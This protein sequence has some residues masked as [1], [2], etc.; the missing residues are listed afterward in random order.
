[1]NEHAILTRAAAITFYAIAALVPFMILLIAL[2]ARVFPWL[3]G[4]AASSHLGQP[5][6]ELLPEDANRFIEGQIARLR[7]QP[8]T[9]L[10]SVGLA[11]MLWLTSSVFV[12]IIDAMNCILDVRESRPYWKR[13]ALAMVMTVSQ[14][15]I[16]AAAVLS[17][18]AWPQIVRQLH[19]GAPGAILATFAH[20]LTVL[21]VILFSF[22]LALY[23]A[24]D[25][26]QR[27]EWITPGSLGGTVVLVGVSFLFR[28][29]VQN[30][31]NYGATYGSLAGVIVLMSW[32]WLCST[33]LLTAA[34]LNAVIKSASP[35]D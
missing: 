29:Y 30:W 21:V 17:I 11:A 20:Q 1:M 7:A 18:V 16:L 13:R 3:A 34:E 24:P 23:I 8:A 9:G 26:D 35:V 6:E 25:A 33:V 5:L 28:A 19:L 10:L 2:V 14:A 12:E 32:L 31:G 15:A 22:G 27:W 4:G